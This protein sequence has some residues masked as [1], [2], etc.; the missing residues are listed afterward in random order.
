MS[1]Q[2]LHLF[3]AALLC[4]GTGRSLMAEGITDEVHGGRGP[5][6]ALP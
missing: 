3:N 2:G 4:L 5:V 1:R 6:E